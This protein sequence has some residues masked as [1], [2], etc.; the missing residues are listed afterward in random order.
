[1]SELSAA[2]PVSSS[3]SSR[4]S[5]IPW[6]P[7]SSHSSDGASESSSFPSPVGD[8]AVGDADT[9]DAGDFGATFSRCADLS[10]GVDGSRARAAF[11]SVDAASPSFGGAVGVVCFAGCGCSSSCGSGFGPP[12]S[13]ADIRCRSCAICVCNTCCD[14]SLLVSLDWVLDNSTSVDS[15]RPASSLFCSIR[16][17]FDFIAC[18]TLRCS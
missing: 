13:S 17:S 5:N 8:I 9:I 3:S 15:S 4:L 6:R 16:A 1:M 11:F 14:C 7:W 2:I 12:A 10:S 18:V